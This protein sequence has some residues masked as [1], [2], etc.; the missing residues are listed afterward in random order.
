MQSI[1]YI[2]VFLLNNSYLPWLDF[3]KVYNE[4]G[5]NLSQ[6]LNKRLE[7]KYTQEFLALVPDRLK[8]VCKLILKMKF[9]EEPPYELLLGCI[10]DEI[11]KYQR[12]RET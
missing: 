11:G 3:K 7:P 2:M 10:R 5:N 6:L 12:E 9:A 1:I 8:L 4:D